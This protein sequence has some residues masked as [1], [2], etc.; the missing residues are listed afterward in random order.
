M[1][2]DKAVLMF[3]GF[4]VLL[5]LVLG[6]T[7]SPYWYLLTAFA[8]LNMFQAAITGFC[9]AAIVFKKLGLRTGSA[10]S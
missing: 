2:L 5:G 9:P 8:G 6:Y 1:N 4:V 3:A 10:F 7:V